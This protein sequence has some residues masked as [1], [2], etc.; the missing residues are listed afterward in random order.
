MLRYS[1]ASGQFADPVR[2]FE[3][4]AL[5]MSRIHVGWVYSPTIFRSWW[6]STPTLH[7]R[8][9]ASR[10]R[11]SRMANQH[12]GPPEF[13]IARCVGGACPGAVTSE[14]ADNVDRTFPR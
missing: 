1:E 7:R 8:F 5:K 6:A 11:R 2:C 3:V 9:N 10:V 13:W 4:P 14:T 12:A